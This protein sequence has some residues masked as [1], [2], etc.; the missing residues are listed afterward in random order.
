MYVVH[1]NNYPLPFNSISCYPFLSN[2]FVTEPG[3]IVNFHN[4]YF[5]KQ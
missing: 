4:G 3:K 5:L 1:F 2:L